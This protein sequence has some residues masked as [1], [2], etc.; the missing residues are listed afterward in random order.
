M[1]RVSQ[2]NRK[3]VRSG[4]V[5]RCQTGF[6]LWIPGIRRSVCVIVEMAWCAAGKRNAEKS[7]EIVTAL[8]ETAQEADEI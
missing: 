3:K 1:G 4:S 5:F 8:F 7:M 2:S 6:A